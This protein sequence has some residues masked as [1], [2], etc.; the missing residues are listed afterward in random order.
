MRQSPLIGR[1][2][3]EERDMS[4]VDGFDAVL[5]LRQSVLSETLVRLLNDQARRLLDI[6]PRQLQ[7][8]LRDPQ[9]SIRLWWDSPTIAA[10]TPAHTAQLTIALAGGMR[11]ASRAGESRR[12]GSLQG[13]LKAQANLH[14]ALHDGIPHVQIND[15]H[16]DMRW[17]DGLRAHYAG[18][19]ALPLANLGGAGLNPN[20]VM[21]ALGADAPPVADLVALISA[22]LAGFAAVPLSYRLEA[23]DG[24]AIATDAD[25]AFF[26]AGAEPTLALTTRRAGPPRPVRSPVGAAPRLTNRLEHGAHS[27]MALALSSEWLSDRLRHLLAT[28]PGLR[29]TSDTQGRPL[30][31]L[32]ELAITVHTGYLTLTGRFADANRAPITVNLA[33]A[34]D[35]KQ[36]RM[37]LTPALPGAPAAQSAHAP[38]VAAGGV[39]MVY[40][41]KLLAAL[42]GMRFHQ[43]GVDGVIESTLAATLPDSLVKLDILV[44]T[45]TLADDALTLYCS[46]PTGAKF[47]PRKPEK[48]PQVALHQAS[49]P[50]QAS[51]GA[52]VRTEAQAAVTT[53]SY[54]RYDVAW[55]SESWLFTFLVGLV[56]TPLAQLARSVLASRLPARVSSNHTLTL[57]VTGVPH[58]ALGEVV[59]LR[60]VKAALIDGF[61]QVAEA[62]LDVKARP[63]KPWGETARRIALAAVVVCLVAAGFGGWRLIP[64]PPPTGFFVAPIAAQ[65]CSSPDQPLPPSTITLN[66][67]GG[68]ASVHWRAVIDPLLP[69]QSA[70]TASWATFANGR[71]D[72]SGVTPAG[73]VTKELALPNVHVCGLVFGASQ[74]E[75]FSVTVTYANKRRIRV[76]ETVQLLHAVVSVNG[77]ST[78]SQEQTGPL[79]LAQSCGATPTSPLS[80]F[81]IVVDNSLSTV[82]ATYQARIT[83]TFAA[84]PLS[85]PSDATQPTSTQAVAIWAQADTTAGTVP[86]G[87]GVTITVSP[88]SALCQSLT[89]YGAPLDFHALVTVSGEPVAVVTDTIT[90]P[91]PLVALLLASYAGSSTCTLDPDLGI[92]GPNVTI[93]LDNTDSTVPVAWQFTTTSVD[94]NGNPWATMTPSSDVVPAGQEELV[95]LSVESAVCNASSPYTGTADLS[96][97]FPQNG[98]QPDIPITETVTYSPP[99]TT[100]V[101]Y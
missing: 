84:G 25:L 22:F 17:W 57:P 63:A 96:L 40:W 89:P 32:N 100:P 50:T 35:G 13:T 70:L 65:V 66:N 77:L 72:I 11:Q 29:Q 30:G 82:D 99:P 90:P 43:T 69:A 67:R 101:I 97:S 37:T 55:K 93:L 75:V 86:A 20:A 68:A 71:G 47:E 48:Q 91:Q 8:P 53:D 21:R 41:G 59:T 4:S 9:P 52:P 62:E 42:L 38:A 3:V 19:S 45:I 2:G 1:T 26:P 28:N 24:V 80:P 7:F 95:T 94:A 58:G 98:Y 34:V 87:K 6:P 33:C 51:P 60:H 83:D 73:G 16:L 78:V 64:P 74:R 88:A 23:L 79:T 12:I 76:T 5:Y 15:A 31:I 14:V 36:R 27:N 49:V 85:T 56:P 81:V 39:S 92:Q 54:A 10:L 61:G 18:S 46:A 44:D